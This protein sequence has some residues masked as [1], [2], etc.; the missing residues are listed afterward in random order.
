MR[1]VILALSV[2]PA[3]SAGD[4]SGDSVRCERCRAS[5]TTLAQGVDSR[6]ARPTSICRFG[7]PTGIGFTNA[8]QLTLEGTRMGYAHKLVFGFG[9]FGGRT[10]AMPPCRRLYTIISRIGCP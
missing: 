8:N 5:E 1:Q 7:D 10:V 9:E 3:S 4:P 6:R 2:S